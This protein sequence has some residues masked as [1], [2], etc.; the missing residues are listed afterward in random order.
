[1]EKIDKINTLVAIEKIENEDSDSDEFIQTLKLPTRSITSFLEFGHV[2][3]YSIIQ[4][5]KTDHHPHKIF[6]LLVMISYS[7]MNQQ[8][9]IHSNQNNSDVWIIP[10]FKYDLDSCVHDLETMNETEFSCKYEHDIQYYDAVVDIKQISI[11][12]TSRYSMI[13]T[14]ASAIHKSLLPKI[15]SEEIP[16]WVQHCHYGMYRFTKDFHYIKISFHDLETMIDP[17]TEC[18]RDKQ[19]NCWFFVQI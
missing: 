5:T 17:I 7:R 10:Q 14:V 9:E 6:G 1:M 15:I 12:F 13:P 3:K 8:E 18:I 2:P 19:C 16:V 11:L 4:Y